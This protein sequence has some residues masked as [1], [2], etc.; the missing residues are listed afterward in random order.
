MA[1]CLSTAHEL[2]LANAR[3]V[4]TDE[5][6]HGTLRLRGGGIASVDTGNTS[7]PGAVDCA[8]D[9]LLPG[10]VELH[11]DNLE[12][13]LMPRP[14]VHWP[15]M[16]AVL[17]HDAEVAGAGITTVYD[18]LGIGDLDARGV[19][20]RDMTAVLDALVGAQEAASLRAEH[21]IHVRAELAVDNTIEL[22]KPFEGH[23]LVRLVSVMDHTPGQRQWR[24][25]GKYR[26]YQQ[27]KRGLSDA[28]MEHFM[29]RA[30]DM[31]ARHADAN[32]AFF[33][34][35]CR[36]RGIALASH[37][38]TTP[39][40]VDAARADGVAI[41]EFPTR[42]EAAQRAHEV[43]LSVV[44][45][46]PNV[47]R[48][49][50]HSGNVAAVELARAGLLDTLSSDYVPSSLLSGAF[51]LTTEAGFTLPRAIRTV[52]LHPARSAGLAD[53]GEIAAG[54]RADIVRVRMLGDQPV[55]RTVWRAGRRV[56]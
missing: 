19:R 33:V 55:V 9:Y 54:Q 20:S 52:T 53:R 23:R 35:Y 4:L 45:G 22:F 11:T 10:L 41:S 7:L 48:G 34:D 8:G 13:H 2:V 31:Q 18:A 44:M 17:A 40:H 32:R 15:V 39:E 24:D 30:R 26:T 37:D 43:G 42:L 51:M 38:D 6:V 14:K 36:V 3:I 28:E 50:S 29:A 46:A 49:G 25:I 27:G 12:R 47:V 21:F 1:R 56:L 16:P 5:V